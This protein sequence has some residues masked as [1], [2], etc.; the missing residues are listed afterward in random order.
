MRNV[1]TIARKELSIYFTT[2]WGWIGGAGMAF[3]SSFFFIY[4][5]GAFRQAGF[6]RVEQTKHT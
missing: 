6:K 1:I 3:L 5:V 2:P 4:F